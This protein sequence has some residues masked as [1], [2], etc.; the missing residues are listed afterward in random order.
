MMLFV[1]MENL[2]MGN[3]LSYKGSYMSCHLI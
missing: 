1:S 2:G 3:L